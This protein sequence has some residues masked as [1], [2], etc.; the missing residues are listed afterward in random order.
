MNGKQ[1]TCLVQL[2]TT[3][4][5]ELRSESSIPCLE[6][7]SD[8]VCLEPEFLP[9]SRTDPVSALFEGLAGAG[10]DIDQLFE[11]EDDLNRESYILN[12]DELVNPQNL[13]DKR[14]ELLSVPPRF[15]SQPTPQTQQSVFTASPTGSPAASPRRRPLSFS[16]NTGSPPT[17]ERPRSP[18]RLDTSSSTLRHRRNSHFGVLADGLGRI[19]N[20]IISSPLAQLF[21]P[22]VVDD[23]PV[24][25]GDSA[26]EH[27]AHLG[28]AGASSS[29]VSIP[30]SVGLVPMPKRRLMSMTGMRHR[31]LSSVDGQSQHFG[32]SLPHHPHVHPLIQQHLAHSPPHDTAP[33]AI[34]A[35]KTV[36]E[37]EEGPPSI[38]WKEWTRRMDDMEQRQQRIE[39]LLVGLAG[40][41]R[42]TG[43]RRI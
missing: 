31:Q 37:R 42:T 10:S 38:D 5:L 41:L 9:C 24:I 2:S 14:P 13:N 33:S 6:G 17:Q 4:S 3:V 18:P 26:P 30:G 22:I 21:Q 36:L 15:Q 39:N 32:A 20:A 11:I 16:G 27:G 19:E 34:P 29:S 40:E 1:S 28:N 12:G 25:I 35:T 23:D 7:S 8:L 43:N